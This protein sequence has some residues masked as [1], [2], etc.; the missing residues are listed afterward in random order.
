M[1]NRL[2]VSKRMLTPSY[3][4]S[5]PLLNAFLA[6]APKAVIGGQF[7]QKRHHFFNKFFT[8][9]K[10][11]YEEYKK[12]ERT[13]LRW[14]KNPKGPLPSIGIVHPGH[15]DDPER[16]T[17][18]MDYMGT[19]RYGDKIPEHT[20]QYRD[21]PESILPDV[22]FLDRMATIWL[23]ANLWFLFTYNLYWNYAKFTGHWYTPYLYE[24]SDEELGIP[25][26]DAPDPEYWG[27]HGKPNNTYR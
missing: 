14:D 17:M 27:H 26:D 11:E 4:N 13:V 7:V 24:F 3:A 5:P 15:Y 8:K 2:F 1:Q 18:D 20:F 12:R 19:K 21:V 25:P 6:N 10:E 23:T 22:P 16:M 9:S